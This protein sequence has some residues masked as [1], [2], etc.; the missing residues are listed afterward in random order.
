MSS[1]YVDRLLFLGAS[2]DY[3]LTGGHKVS[4]FCA[5]NQKCPFI[6]SLSPTHYGIAM[7]IRVE[8]T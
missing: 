3:P 7:H 2:K 8:V 6:I 1:L 5:S 4:M